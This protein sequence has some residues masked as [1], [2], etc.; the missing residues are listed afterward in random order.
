[1]QPLEDHRMITAIF[2][3]LLN[4]SLQQNGLYVQTIGIAEL[5]KL[6]ARLVSTSN[7]EAGW[8]TMIL[9]AGEK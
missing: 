9:L 4:D 8:E 2:V 6:Y 5:A 3:D 7:T 1:M